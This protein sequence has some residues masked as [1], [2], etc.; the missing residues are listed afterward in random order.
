MVGGVAAGAQRRPDRLG[1]VG[2]P[3]GDRG[4]RAGAGQHRGGGHGQD[5]DQ[6]VAA[7]PGRSRVGDGG[8]G[9]QQVRA[10][11]VLELAR[12]GVGEAGQGGWGRE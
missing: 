3:F 2:G 8:E 12:V 4:D 11:G 9:A 6:R 5:G 7:A 1:R 10:V